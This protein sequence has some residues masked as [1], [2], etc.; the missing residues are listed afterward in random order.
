MVGFVGVRAGW[1][2][3]A[4]VLVAMA[5]LVFGVVRVILWRD[6]RAGARRRAAGEPPSWPAQ[7]PLVVARQMGATVS[8]RHSR[9]DDVGELFGR[10]SSVD[11]R[12][13]WQPRKATERGVGQVFWDRMWSAEVKRIRGTRQPGLPDPDRVRRVGGRR[14]DPPSR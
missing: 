2:A 9:I 8:G 11:S 13:R 14:V 3:A 6:V 5:L 7:M 4:V 10:L 12:L 1:L